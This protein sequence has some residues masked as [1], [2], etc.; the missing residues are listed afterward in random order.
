VDV[1]GLLLLT[2]ALAVLLVVA[3]V[4]GSLEVLLAGFYARVIG[5]ASERRARTKRIS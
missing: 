1:S 2:A 4:G 3:V 5:A